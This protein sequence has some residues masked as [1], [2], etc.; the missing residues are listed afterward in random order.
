MKVGTD[1]VQTRDDVRDR[2]AVC[3]I[4]AVQEKHVL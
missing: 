2:K 1:Q 4:D 3:R